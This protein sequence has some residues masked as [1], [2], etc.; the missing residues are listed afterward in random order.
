M[1]LRAC[2]RVLVSLLIICGVV[3]AKAAAQQ[4]GPV[5]SQGDHPPDL[6]AIQHFVF[7]IKENRSFDHYFGTYPG[8]NGVT[9]GPISTGQVVPLTHAPDVLPRDIGHDWVSSVTAMDNG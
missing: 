5:R 3:C 4:P 6:T 2:P 8:A 7:I 1:S 9:S